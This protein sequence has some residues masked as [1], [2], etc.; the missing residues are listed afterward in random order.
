MVNADMGLRNIDRVVPLLVPGIGAQGGDVEAT[1][2]A[3]RTAAGTGMI[4]NNSRAVL[5]AGKDENY[6]QAS[7]QAALASRDL[8]NRYR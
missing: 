2:K 5:Y 7:R 3:G 1:L 8:I 4:I 6:A